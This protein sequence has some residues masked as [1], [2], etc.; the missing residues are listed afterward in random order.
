MLA[1]QKEGRDHGAAGLAWWQRV[2][3]MDHRQ[4]TERRVE[5]VHM[6]VAEQGQLEQLACDQMAEWVQGRV[7]QQHGR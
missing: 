3:H 1:G 7:E 6:R 2:E 5:Q 4:M